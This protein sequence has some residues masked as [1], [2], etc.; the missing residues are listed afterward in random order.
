MIDEVKVRFSEIPWEAPGTGV[1]F[2]A[3]TRDGKKV[4]LVEFTNEFIEEDWCENGHIGYV[5]EGTLEVSFPQGKVRFSAGDGVFILGGES[6]K[7][8]ASVIGEKVRLIL[9]EKA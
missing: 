7:H 6:E 8:K 5:L 1:R 9:V 3:F 2:K 4:R